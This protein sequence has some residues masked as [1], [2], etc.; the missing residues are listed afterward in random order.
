M[1]WPA[2][3]TLPKVQTGP[4]YFGNAAKPVEKA[5]DFSRFIDPDPVRWIGK[6]FYIPET[7]S[8]MELYP[9]QIIPLREALRRG[10]DG[11]FVY[12]TVVWSAIKKSAKS[13]IAAAIGLWMAWQRSWSS[14]K[15]IAN[16]LKQADSRV[17]Y[18]M[19]RAILLHPEWK[20]IVKVAGYKITLPNHSIIEAIP[21]DPEG[22]AGGGDDLVI[23]SELWGWKSK[24]E[25]AMWTESTLSP[26]KYGQSIRWCE[27]YAGFIGES[28]IL[29]KLHESG[30]KEGKSINTEYEMYANGRLFVLWNTTPHLPW[31]SSLYYEQEAMTLEDNEFRRVHK[32]EFVS[33]TE[34]FVQPE[35]WQACKGALPALEDGD[36]C[37]V[38]MDAAVS[39]DCFGILMVSRSDGRT[40]PRQVRKWTPPIGGKITYEPPEGTSPEDAILYPSGYVKHLVETFNVLEVGYDP[41]QLHSLATK[42]SQDLICYFRPFNQVGD[43]L[44]A[45]KSLQDAIKAREVL[46]DGNEDLSE[47]ILNAAAKSEGDKSIRIVKKSSNKKIDL[48][49][50]LSMGHFEAVRLGI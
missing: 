46:H 3:V 42:L 33:S 2:A 41:Y 35:W 7:N 11:K 20:D 49:V 9:S 1:S 47:H 27:T 30:V 39:G 12:S 24:A 6:H 40:I 26:L 10:S 37:V 34:S 36:P 23:Y 21:I 50:C 17:A 16:D 45:D 29:E 25:L 18:Y 4:F 44:L 38:I 22:E 13:A 8:P 48:A 5:D 14:I 32:N 15:V 28:P 19:R 43:R 31:Q